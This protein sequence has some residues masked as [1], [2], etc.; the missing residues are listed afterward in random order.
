MSN[1][2]NHIIDP[3]F[4]RKNFKSEFRLHSGSVFLSNM[5]L[6]N[7]GVKEDGGANTNYNP[8]TGAFCINSIQ[9]LD[10]N[11]LIDQVLEASIH[12]AFK[13]Y[14]KSNDENISVENDL[15][16]N[17]LGYVM[18]GTTTFDNA[19]PKRPNQTSLKI[20]TENGASVTG[21]DKFRRSW[22][23]LKALLPF[24]SSSLYVP[25]DTFKNLKLVVNWKS[26]EQ[27]KNIVKAQGGTYSTLE[28][29]S[30]VVEEVLPGPARSAMM[31]NYEGVRYRAI[32]SD[33]VSVPAITAIPADS[34]KAQ[35]NRFLINGFNGKTVERMVVVQTPTDEATWTNA[36]NLKAAGNQGSVAQHKSTL[37]IRVNGANKI[38]RT[39]LTKKNQRLA[40]LSDTWG[41]CNLIPGSNSVFYKA[42]EEKNTAPAKEATNLMGQ[43][44]YMGCEVREPVRELVLEYNRV[45]VTNNAG[46]N[47]RLELNVFGEVNKAVSVDKSSKQYVVSY[48]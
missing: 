36:G 34:E 21:E 5:R 37:Q 40:M 20:N 15:T 41:E 25:T 8:L 47:Q 12:Q 6:I 30:L 44:D 17:N 48:I 14:N 2:R 29:S 39:G 26:P 35:N 22:L 23:N 10:G 28:E 38:P 13:N 16:K 24:L 7:M 19:T 18:A 3:V 1:V 4:D 32:E 27:L 11:Q 42:L 31:M 9:L 45:G 43:F 46:L 33:K